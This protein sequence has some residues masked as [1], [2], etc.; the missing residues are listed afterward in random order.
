MGLHQREKCCMLLHS[1]QYN[2]FLD[3]S[4]IFLGFITMKTDKSNII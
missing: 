3:A 2:S 4:V 1:Y